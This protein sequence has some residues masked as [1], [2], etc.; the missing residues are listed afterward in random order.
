MYQQGDVQVVPV[1]I[2]QT[3]DRLTVAAPMPG[4]MPQDVLV[5]VT[6]DGQLLL[7]G[8]RRGMLKDDK[9]VLINEWDVGVY[10]RQIALPV[11][12]AGDLATVTYGNGVLVVALPLARRTSGAILALEPGQRGHGERVGSAGRPVKGRSNAEFRSAREHLIA[13]HGGPAG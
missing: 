8:N 12:V 1:K 13:D 9:T 3:D 11:N 7:S 2:Y 5:V 4:L 10:R 6:W